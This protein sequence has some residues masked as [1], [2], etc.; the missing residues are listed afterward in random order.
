MY[1]ISSSMIKENILKVRQSILEACQQTGRDPAQVSIVCVTKSRGIPEINE[2][3]SSGL[4]NIGENKVQEALLKY[5][6]LRPGRVEIAPITW[7]MIGHLQ[8]NKAKEA[9][10]IFNLIHSVDSLG[11]AKE[12]DKQARRIA[13]VQEILLEVKTSPEES[14]SGFSP[15]DIP[16]VNKELALFSNIKVRGL[17]TIAPLIADGQNARPYFAALRKLRDEV[18]P[19]WLLSMGMSDDFQAAILEGADIIRLGRVIFEG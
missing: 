7:H 6:A 16:A 15:T 9:V 11:L 18:D 13:K 1:N 8:S 12:I 19:G 17:M 2:A 14:K 3:L 5:D 10:R 4:L